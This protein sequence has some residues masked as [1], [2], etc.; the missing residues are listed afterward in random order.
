[1]TELGDAFAR[2]FQEQC[3]HEVVQ[4]AEATGW[5]GALW[6]VVAEAGVPWIS[7]PEHANG[8]G[9]TL[10]DAIEVLRLCGRFAVPLPIAETGMLGGWLLASAGLEMPGVEPVAVAP[11]RPHDTVS[12]AANGTL[13]GVAHDVAWARQ[14]AALCLIVDGK[15]AVV[16]R[17]LMTVTPS[18]NMAGEPRDRVGFS[19][20]TAD[21]RELPVGVDA[22]AL[23]LRGSMSRIAM[24]SGALER[25]SEITIGYAYEREQFGQVIGRFQAVQQHLV[26]M[27]EETAMAVMATDMAVDACTEAG[28]VD[29]VEIATA[30]TIVDEAAA[31]VT[32][33]AHQTHGAIGM[34]QEYRLH[35]FSRRVWAWRTEWGHETEWARRLG[36]VALAGRADGLW[37]LITGAPTRTA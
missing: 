34:T 2:M 17:T 26:H 28:I 10:A 18:N 12:L 30:R 35:Q 25:I 36:D 7:V 11:G 21:I 33:A 4:E 6:S 9:G 31:I 32:A 16:P 13:H 1:M 14:A 20:V 24:M 8:S 23:R 29:P 27:A 37:P 19:G 15:L 22:E 5:A 3:T